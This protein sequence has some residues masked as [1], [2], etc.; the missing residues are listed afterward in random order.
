MFYHKP[1]KTLQYKGSYICSASRDHP[2]SQGGGAAGLLGLDQHQP[3]R[4]PPPHPHPPLGRLRAQPV[5]RSEGRNL[6]L[7]D[8]QPL[9]PRHGGRE[10]DQH[11]AK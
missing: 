11:E 5:R 3:G 8:R 10:S 2:L 6:A 1:C 4:G 7:Q 9:L